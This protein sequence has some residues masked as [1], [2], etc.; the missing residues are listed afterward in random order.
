MNGERRSR[1]SNV[2]FWWAVLI[3]TIGTFSIILMAAASALSNESRQG[4][5]HHVQL[6]AEVETNA[7]RYRAVMQRVS[8][9]EQRMM[10][11]DINV[12]ALRW[13]IED[14]RDETLKAR[15]RPGKGHMSN[16]EILR[17]YRAGG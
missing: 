11:L 14:L 3:S 12:Q 8:I 10:T 7:K 1:Y 15:G 17:K 16:R 5:S 6:V 2:Y 9:A 4:R 13:A